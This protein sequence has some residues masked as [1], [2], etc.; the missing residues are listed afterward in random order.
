MAPLNPND[1]RISAYNSD[2]FKL[3]VDLRRSIIKTDPGIYV[4]SPAASFRAGQILTL[5]VNGNL[6]VCDGTA[7]GKPFGMAKFDK[8]S[9][10]YAAKVDE[11]VVLTLLVPSNLKRAALFGSNPGVT[12][13]SAPLGGGTLYVEGVD[14]AVNYVNGT[15]VRVGVGIPSGSTV[16]V[17]YQFQLL[18][19]DYDFQGRNFW[20]S[21]DDVTI[22]DGRITVIQ[23]WSIIFTT[24]YDPARTY[25]L[26]QPIHVD[27]GALAGVLT[28]NTGG[29]RPPYGQVIQL[30][31]ADDP[32]L[33]V[34]A[35]AGALTLRA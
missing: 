23:D 11:P 28:N 16:F 10:K 31:T 24:V 22:Q 19:Q 34:K 7:G 13:R 25:A 18:E 33:G 20:N 9:I 35:N 8:T 12:V 5:D 1:S 17:T 14:Y 32:F 4:A 2:P 27:G 15:I 6:V 30:P 21:N 3:G 26:L 29:G